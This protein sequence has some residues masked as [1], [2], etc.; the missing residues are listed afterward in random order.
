MQKLLCLI[1]LAFAASSCSGRGTMA[2]IGQ[3]RGG[4]TPQINQGHG[5]PSGWEFLKTKSMNA[6][7]IIPAKGHHVWYDSPVDNTVGVVDTR[8]LKAKEFPIPNGGGFTGSNPAQLFGNFFTNEVWVALT[9]GDPS[10]AEYTSNGTGTL[11][12]VSEMP[13]GGICGFG[14][15]SPVYLT[16]V[17]GN[18][19]E[20]DPGTGSSHDVAARLPDG[21]AKQR[22]V[23]RHGRQLQ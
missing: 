15:N 10:I 9:G 3:Q 19:V 16:S 13:A 5:H 6:A 20:Y 1:L 21:R 12:K 22:C 18:L 14:K 7:Y 4:I 17:L 11:H 8:T 23:H 2:P